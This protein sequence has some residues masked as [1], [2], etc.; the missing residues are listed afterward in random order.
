[1]WDHIFKKLSNHN[2]KYLSNIYIY[3]WII[4]TNNNSSLFGE[5]AGQI[6]G[7]YKP[8]PVNKRVSRLERT[9][10]K[11]KCEMVIKSYV[12]QL[13]CGYILLLLLLI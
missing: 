11:H 6:K 3:I 12:S 8:S 1:M 10:G 9:I 7:L 2:D 4:I 13:L 5:L